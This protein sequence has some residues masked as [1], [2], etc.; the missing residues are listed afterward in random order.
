MSRR[1]LVFFILI[2]AAGYVMRDTELFS[3]LTNSL[4]G[5]GNAVGKLLSPG[6]GEKKKLRELE[7]ALKAKENILSQM[8]N[9]FA[10]LEANPKYCSNGQMAFNVTNDPRAKLRAEIEALKVEIARNSAE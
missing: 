2:A 7:S 6:P 3:K 10:E 1:I 4:P 5:T 8:E 9:K